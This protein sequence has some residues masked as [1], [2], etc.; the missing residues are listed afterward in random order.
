MPVNRLFYILI[1]SACLAAKPVAAQQTGELLEE[2]FTNY[3]LANLQ[4]KIYLHTDKDFYLAG[5]TIWFKAYL[6][7]VFF[8]KPL[9]ISRIAYIDV[10][11]QNGK[12]VLQTSISI[13]YNATG[14]GS[15]VIP[16]S[17]SSGHYTIRAYTN[18]MKNVGAAAFFSKPITIVNTLSPWIAKTNMEQSDSVI[19]NLYPEGGNMV[20]GLRSRVAFKLTNKFGEPVKGSGLLTTA[21]NDT[22][23]KFSATE[24]GTGSFYFT[25]LQNAQYRIRLTDNAVPVKV[26]WPLIFNEGYVM[27]LK[28]SANSISVKIHGNIKVDH[29]LYL[30]IHTRHISKNFQQAFLSAQGTTEFNVDLAALGEGVSHFTIFNEKRQPVCERLFFKH[31]L[32]R[33]VVS[34]ETDKAQYTQREKA[35]AKVSIT[36]LAGELGHVSLSASV[37]L[38]DSL[39]HEPGDDI[40]SYLLLTSELGGRIDKPLQFFRE[41]DAF[42]KAKLDELMLINGWSRFRWEEV[43]SGDGDCFKFLPEREGQVVSATLVHK[44]NGQPLKGAAA[45]LAIPGPHFTLTNAVSDNN[46][47]LNFILK[48]PYQRGEMILQTVS[49]RDSNYTFEMKP[50]YYPS[51]SLVATGIPGV[52]VA[53]A[54]QLRR[55]STFMQV[56]KSFNSEKKMPPASSAKTDTTLFYG[57]SARE[58]NLDEYTRFLTMEEVLKEFIAE[59]AVEQRGNNYHFRV[60]DKSQGLYFESDPLILID[61]V[62]VYDAGKMMAFD[63]LMIKSIDVVPN[64][65]F[66]HTQAYEGIVS[67]KTYQGDLAGYQLDPNAIVV[68]YEALQQQQEYYQPSYDTDEKRKSRIPDFRN[69]LLWQPEIQ[70]DE[71]GTASFTFYTSGYTGKF[72]VVV[73]GISNTGLPISIT[74]TVDVL[75]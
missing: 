10:I 53:H 37:Y 66:H 44:V 40:V 43:L 39:Q 27:E 33:A 51:D 71:N 38:I 21:K 55:R 65:Y 3:H 75:P 73:Q 34:L 1:L 31:P 6:V 52:D 5:E 59:V 63:P 29:S 15:F 35:T 13:S 54:E 14:T 68:E 50:A 69:V 23:L 24:S 46:G 32:K 57:Q 45:F 67:F 62:P 61:G 7:D 30:L 17:L 11:D 60:K 74:R 48:P 8:H 4:E 22:V 64:R 20:Y 58:Y 19:L 25:P 41:N 26:N 47:N 56:E 42:K 36:Q 28:E 2:Q 72:L 12:P 9:A 70:P 18:I 16:A 49:S